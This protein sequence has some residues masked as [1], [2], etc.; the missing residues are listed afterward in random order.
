LLAVSSWLGVASPLVVHICV[1]LTPPNALHVSVEE[2]VHGGLVVDSL[3]VLDVRVLSFE[4]ARLVDAKARP[5]KPK[6]PMLRFS[7]QS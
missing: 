2:V 1:V 5:K 7:L 4:R 3:L 6:N